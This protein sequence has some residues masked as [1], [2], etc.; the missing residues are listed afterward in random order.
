M[1]NHRVLQPVILRG[2]AFED[3]IVTP[4]IWEIV[5]QFKATGIFEKLSPAEFHNGLLDITLDEP[6][7]ETDPPSWILRSFS[8]TLTCRVYYLDPV[9]ELD[10]PY[11]GFLQILSKLSGGIFNPENI[12][13]EYDQDS[14]DDFNFSFEINGQKFHQTLEY[15]SDHTDL[16]FMELVKKAVKTH[17]KDGQ[18]Y[19]YSGGE[20]IIF[21]TKSQHKAL[22]KKKIIDFED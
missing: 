3:Y 17:I 21:L 8:K 9:D 20:Y 10:K 12:I 4:E 1:Q 14:L 19:F 22:K 6:F 15:M 16:R 13:D 2:N 11:Q 7:E 5:N 18:F